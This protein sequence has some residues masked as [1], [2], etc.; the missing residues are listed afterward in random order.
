MVRIRNVVAPSASRLMASPA[1]MASP[2]RS[3]TTIANT[4]ATAIAAIAAAT[5]AHERIA[6]ARRGDHRRERPGQHQALE[7]DVEDARPLREQP[8]KG[9][10]QDG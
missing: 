1:T 6:G 8:P 9:R 7:R 2:P 10:Q 5:H 3:T 4:S